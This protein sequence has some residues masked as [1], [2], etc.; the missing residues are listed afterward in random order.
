MAKAKGLH[1]TDYLKQPAKHPAEAVCVLFGGDAF[2]KSH[3]FKKLRAA[4][5]SDDDNGGGN[6]GDAEFSL[7]RFDGNQAVF[8]VVLRELSMMTMF[9]DG[10]R[11][12]VVDDADPFISKFRGELEDYAA[13]PSQASTLILIAGTFPAT[14]RLYK[15]VETSGFLVDCSPLSESAI[16]SW[17]TAWAKTGHKTQCDIAAAELLVDLIGPELG[18]LDQELAK[19]ALIVPQGQTLTATLVQENVG[20]WRTRT[21][22]EM[23]DLALIGNVP[24]AVR[25]LDMLMQAGENPVGILAQIAYSLRRLAAAT[26]L[27][28]DAERQGKRISLPTALEQAGVKRFVIQKSESQLKRLGRHRGDKLLDWLLKADLDLKGDSRISPRMIIEQLILKI[29]APQL[30]L[31]Q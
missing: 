24:E 10:Q 15:T 26:Q 11:V 25:Q 8:P 5:L 7:T 21:T 2:L 13:K 1:A 22:W 14:T 3:V 18:L 9:G 31:P 19:L 17:L 6:G 16:P 29:S 23:L 28:L 27:I 30:R 4:L 12:V 20:S